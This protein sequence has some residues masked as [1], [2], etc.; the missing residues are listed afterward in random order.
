L[1][2]KKFTDGLESLFSTENKEDV[3]GKGTA[4]LRDSYDGGKSSSSSPKT[5]KS[6]GSSRKTFTTDLD[7]LLEEA[8]QESF[9]E[10]MAQR[11]KEKKKKKPDQSKYQNQARRRPM[12]GLDV[13]IRRTVEINEIEQNRKKGTKRLTVTF[14]KS[15]IAKLKRL[16]R[17]EKAYHKDILGDLVEE[18]I[19]SYESDKGKIE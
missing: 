16:A 19:Q 14:D 2:K 8:L 3:S 17:L 9:E 5:K 12:T 15:K 10:K 1:S 6:R 7:T 13:L 11:E 18:Y 4:F